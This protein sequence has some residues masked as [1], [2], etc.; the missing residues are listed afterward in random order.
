MEPYELSVAQS[1]AA[2]RDGALSPTELMDSLLARVAALEPRLSAWV[3]LDQEA[4]RSAARQAENEL[5]RSG[6][7][8]PLHGVPVGLKDIFCSTGAPTTACSRLFADYVPDYDATCVARLREAGVVV[9]GKLVTT[10]Y[11]AGDPSPTV[12]PWDADRTP[13]GSSSGSA[14][15]VATRMCAAALG[16][17]TVGSTLRPAAYA[18]IV[19]L[20]PTFGRISLHGILPLGWSLDT[21]GILVRT[22]VDAALLLGVMA[23]YDLQDPVSACE[24]VIDYLPSPAA[25]GRP[26]RIGLLRGFFYEHADE[27]VR[28]HTDTVAQRLAGAG[29]EVLK[30]A[31][32]PSFTAHAEATS[33]TFDVEV[34]ATH[35]PHYRSDPAL[36]PPV[37]RSVIERGLAT[38]AQ[39]YA[40]AQQTRARFRNELRTVFDSVDILIGPSAPAQAPPLQEGTTG[41]PL[42]QGPWTSAG[43]P[44][45]S[46]PSGL[47]ASGL[48]LGVQMAAPWFQEKHL[49][50]VARWCE[51][52]LGEG[53]APP[54]VG[55]GGQG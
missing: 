29:A 34:A 48:P 11:A 12:N 17:Q 38:S 43:L 3:T 25:Q 46:I 2:I 54:M 50:D 6:P 28:R 19:G 49:I 7:R 40:A 16:S 10:A 23:G 20:K 45:I 39:A 13:G 27:D 15:A 26:P 9:M 4:A 8:G 52:V 55:Q 53:P 22:V 41:P 44:A 42:F 33:T 5:A 14:V 30:I 47:D 36:Y 18:G 24:P 32:P 21:V 31:D 37:I 51:T 35:E 1:A